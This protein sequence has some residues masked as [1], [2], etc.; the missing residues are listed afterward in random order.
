VDDGVLVDAGLRTGD[1]AIWAAG[2][3]ARAEN[4]WAGR[5]LRWASTRR[6]HCGSSVSVRPVAT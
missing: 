6:D 3:V 4:D 5:R 1:P 2:D